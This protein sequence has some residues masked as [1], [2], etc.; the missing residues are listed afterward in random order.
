MRLSHLLVASLVFPSGLL[1]PDS[2]SAN[3]VASHDP[4]TVHE[5]MF[6]AVLRSVDK[7]VAE[8]IKEERRKLR[9]L[10]FE[11]QALKSSAVDEQVVQRAMQELRDQRVVVSER[12][13]SAIESNKHLSRR[14]A[15]IREGYVR[16]SRATAITQRG[17][18]T[19]LSK[20]R[21]RIDRKLQFM[22][23]RGEIIA[24]RDVVR[25]RIRQG[26]QILQ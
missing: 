10:R 21:Q 4:L 1:A 26:R 15:D 20:Q 9:A 18:A 3:S 12:L 13:R 2:S 25:H 23:L 22:R 17:A 24:R 7:E 16:R 8:N 5:L 11:V 6:Q 19:L 14:L